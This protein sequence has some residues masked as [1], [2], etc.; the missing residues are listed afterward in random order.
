MGAEDLAKHL[1]GL[2][3]QLRW[4]AAKR[5]PDVWLRRRPSEKDIAGRKRNPT[6]DASQI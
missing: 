6:L 5:Q 3:N 1:D 2:T 4:Q